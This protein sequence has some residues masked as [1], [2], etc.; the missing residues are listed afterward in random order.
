MYSKQRY[1]SLNITDDAHQLYKVLIFK[2][3]AEKT[4]KIKR[5]VK[6]EED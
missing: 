1:I 3:R 2:W 4:Q 6:W 5:Q